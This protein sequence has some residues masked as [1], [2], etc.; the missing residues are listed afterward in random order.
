MSAL[1]L[2]QQTLLQALFGA[3]QEASKLI[4]PHA[5]GA[6][7][8]GLKAYQSNGHALAQRSLQATYPVLA[9]LLGEESFEALACALWHAQPPPRGD[10]ALWG[11]TLPA[12]VA[13]SAQLA[14]EP[15]LAD[16][17]RVEW[18]LHRAASAADA[19]PELATLALMTAHEPAQLALRLAPGTAVVDS[20]YPVA[21][22]VT[23][24]LEG[25]P[26][27]EEAGQRLRA[28]LGEAALVWR[29]GFK[30]RVR[31]AQPGEAAFVA[32]LL[33]PHARHCVSSLPPEGA[34]PALGR[35]GGG[36]S[37]GSLATALERAG[38]L[39]FPSWLA[40]AVHSGLLLAVTANGGTS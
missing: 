34:Q 9:Q 31:A 10:L 23:A 38:P 37:G 11:E 15:Y 29:Q 14:D 22:I 40:Q 3:P 2:Q 39:D 24:H 4:A 1:A 30:P 21:S 8:R 20:F 33:D 16:V 18:A 32:A 12:F 26:T 28:G 7:A 27:L 19:Q 36:W 17:A 5:H 35:P 6:W 25:Q 13:V